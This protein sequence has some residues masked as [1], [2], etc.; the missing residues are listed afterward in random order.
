MKRIIFLVLVALFFAIQGGAQAFEFDKSPNTYDKRDTKQLNTSLGLLRS[1][2]LEEAVEA[3]SLIRD[4]ELKWMMLYAISTDGYASRGEIEKAVALMEEAVAIFRKVTNIESLVGDSEQVESYFEAIR[5]KFFEDI[6]IAAVEAGYLEKSLSVFSKISRP[7]YHL[8][9]IEKVIA[10]LPNKEVVEDFL[11][12]MSYKL[13]S[14]NGQK[15]ASLYFKD[16]YYLIILWDDNKDV[17]I[18]YHKLTKKQLRELLD[19]HW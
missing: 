12:K 15:M 17:R 11:A 5:Q 13:V 10:R 8:Q 4:Y 2:S 14:S 16:P 7:Y 6:I 1:G 9:A 19:S 18:A 3:T